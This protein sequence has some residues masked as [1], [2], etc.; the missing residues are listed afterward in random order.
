MLLFSREVSLPS[1]LGR[2]HLRISHT[3]KLTEVTSTLPLDRPWG[4]GN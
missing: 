4:G 1:S 3:A 2:W